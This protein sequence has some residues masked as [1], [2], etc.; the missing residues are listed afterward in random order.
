MARTVNEQEYT[1]KRKEILNAAQRLVLTRGYSRMTIGDILT[2]LKISSGAFYHYFPSKPAVLEA[3][4]EHMQEQAEQDIVELVR[5]PHLAALEKLQRFFGWIDQ[6]RTTQQAHVVDLMRV[7]Y[8]DDNAIVRQKVEAAALIRRAPL[9]NEIIRQGIREG[10][11]N[12][13]YPDQAGEVVLSLMQGMGSAHIRLL[14]SLIPER[15]DAARSAADGDAQTQDI[16]SEIVAIHAAFMDAVERAL[17]AP[18]A[19]LYRADAGVARAWVN[20]VQGSSR[21]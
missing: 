10:T 21:N 8:T 4:I 2:E 17:G 15:G 12:T 13:T 6:A 5:D 11:F 19:C 7:W 18:Q 9:L 16:V 3:L 20:A 14:L 1:E